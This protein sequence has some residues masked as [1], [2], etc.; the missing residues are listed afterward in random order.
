MKIRLSAECHRFLWKA[1]AWRAK[2]AVRLLAWRVRPRAYA[3]W[4]PWLQLFSW[5]LGTV[6]LIWCAVVQD[7][8][9]ATVILLMFSLY[10]W[11]PDRELPEVRANA[12]F[13]LI[14]ESGIPIKDREFLRLT[15]VDE[16][17][18]RWSI[19]DQTALNERRQALSGQVV[20]STLRRAQEPPRRM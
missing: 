9:W 12:L 19:C 18:A 4:L 16:T 13:D 5:L 10:R 3:S 11:G 2:P 7:Q 1:R 6:G 17:L 8:G 14:G 20:R 15:R